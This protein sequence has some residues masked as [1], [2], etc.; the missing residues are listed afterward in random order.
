MKLV[1]RYLIALFIVAMA[2]VGIVAA[3]DTTTTF[4]TGPFTASVLLFSY[5][6]LLR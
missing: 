4:K 5:I 6:T 2:S 1:A 3:S